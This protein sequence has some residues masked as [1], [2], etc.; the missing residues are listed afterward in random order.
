MDEA[1]KRTV[2][3]WYGIFLGAFTVAIGVALIVLASN[4]YFSDPG[5]NGTPF[6]RE[7]LG[8]ELKK[9]IAPFVLW[10]LAVIGGYVLSVLFPVKDE[11]RPL[12]DDGKTVRKLRRR[13]PDGKS[14]A[15][16]EARKQDKKFIIARIAVWSVCAAFAVASGIVAVVYLADKSHFPAADV[17]G[18]V[19]GML[20]HI[21]PWIA[22]SSVLFVGATV[23]EMTV[24]K[25]ELA[26][27]K[28][29]LVLGKGTPVK[30]GKFERYGAVC[31]RVWN[32]DITLWA[33]RGAVFVLAVVFLVLGIVNGGMGDVLRKAI[34]ICTECIGLG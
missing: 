16:L 7:I 23:Y 32:S 15:F 12:R 1:K 34:I 21:L 24:A 14:E 33:V 9:M 28:R 19:I 5:A 29:L 30:Q 11:L 27:V 25:R 20:R 8:S 13:I 4:L 3:F 6:T 22:V 17:T 18:E 26:S 2:R 10:V 31:A